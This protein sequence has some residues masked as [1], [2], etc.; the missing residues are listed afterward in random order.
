MSS[1]L[2]LSCRVPHLFLQ[3]SAIQVGTL[4]YMSPEAILGGTNNIRGAPPMKVGRASDV[5]SLGCILYQ[6]VYGHTP[7][8]AL[9]FIQKMH[10]ITDPGYRVAFPP[11]KN[12]ALADTIKRCLDRSPR[13]RIPMQVTLCTVGIS[14]MR[15]LL[16][17]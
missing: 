9:A 3:S 17:P 16:P 6:M 1:G 15:S 7:F 4:N 13:T 8:S 2:P 12:A 5:W 10:A 14:A 11:I